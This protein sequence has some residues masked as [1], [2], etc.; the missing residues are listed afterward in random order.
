MAHLT[1]KT[2]VSPAAQEARFRIQ[3]PNSTAR[4]IVVIPLDEVSSGLVTKTAN[5]PWRNARFVA[6]AANGEG[7]RAALAA[8]DIDLVVI[9]GQVGESLSQTIAIGETVVTRHIKISGVLIVDEP[10]QLTALAGS[11]RSIRPWT[12]TLAVIGNADDLPELL[13]ALGA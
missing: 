5:Q 3:A 2:L 13:H 12:H 9:I 6:Y 1:I 11:L 8:H 10:A 7:W 4:N